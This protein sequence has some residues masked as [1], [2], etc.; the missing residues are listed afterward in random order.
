MSDDS[1]IPTERGS[2]RPVTI[3]GDPDART[4]YVEVRAASPRTGLKEGAIVFVNFG[5]P[6]HVENWRQCIILPSPEGAAASGCHVR[7]SPDSRKAP[8][9]LG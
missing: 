8:T 4:Y 3:E 6:Q 7:L 2:V 1:P 9:K 5:Q